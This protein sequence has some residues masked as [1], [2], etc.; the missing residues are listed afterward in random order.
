[1]QWACSI[2][3]AVGIYFIVAFEDSLFRRM[4]FWMVPYVVGAFGVEEYGV[5]DVSVS[6]SLKVLGVALYTS[7]FVSEVFTPEDFIHHDFD[8]VSDLYVGMDVKGADVAEEVA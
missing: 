4:Y 2:S 5:F 7:D 1:M 3:S 6:A 8:V